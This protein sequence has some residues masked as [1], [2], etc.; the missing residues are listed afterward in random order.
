M[1]ELLL[2]PEVRN[3]IREHEN[4]DERALLLKHKTLFNLPAS[5][6]ANQ[7]AGRRK[8][9]AKLPLYY[10]TPGI[11]FPPGLNLEQS[12][13]E[14]TALF[15]TSLLGEI[16][17]EKK[18]VVDLTGGFGIDSFFLS[19]IF[20]QVD[21]IEPNAELLEYARHNHKT[22]GVHHI[23][24]HHTT[25]EHF[26]NS[27]SQH[28]CVFIDPS[29]RTAANKKVFR[30]ADCEPDIV[31]LLP[32]IFEHTDRL[33]IKTSPLLD[34]QHGI[35]ELSSVKNVWVVS[36]DNDCKEL[37]FLCEKGFAGEPAITA[38]NLGTAHERF[39]F[40]FSDEKNA[41][42][43]FSEPLTYLYEPNA[44]ILKAGAFKRVAEIFALAKIH[45]NTHLYTSVNFIDGFPGRI[46]KINHTV[47][48]EAKILA[49]LL[50]EGKA[51]V[52]TRNYPLSPDELKKKLKV[53][54][55]G[56]YYVIG[57]TGFKI[58]HFVIAERIK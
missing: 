6:V 44:S 40:N 54:D 49:D 24:H 42:T 8:A 31:N 53:N 57:F 9:K 34:I 16:L 1:I 58:R 51:N 41:V 10:T 39:V 52:L 14:E 27:T 33:L 12:S 30:L 47:K 5:L 50:P 48:P 22:L 56:K 43:E 4:E 19:K 32:K 15:K 38:I 25:A 55:G 26:L 7:I 36:V 21:Y 18:S 29:R 17:S 3:F 45:P 28:D 20:D 2:Q 46:F 23:N 37:L 13:S 11:V 35:K